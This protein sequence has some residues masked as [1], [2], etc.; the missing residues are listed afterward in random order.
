MRPLRSQPSRGT[1]LP[2]PQPTSL[3]SNPI[4][5]QPNLLCPSITQQYQYRNIN[6]LSIDYAFRPRLRTR[7][8]LG[9]RTFPRKPW[10]F[11]DRDSHPVFRYSCLHGHFCT[12]QP[13][14]LPTFCAVQNALL[15]RC[16]RTIRVFGYI[17]ES[18]SFS[19]QNHSISELLRTL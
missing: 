15:P 8:T 7:L 13:E 17:L 5:S 14:S 18:R 6:L 2:I 9:G 10:N 12:L 4:R 16:L 3:D 1:D 19:A 11:G